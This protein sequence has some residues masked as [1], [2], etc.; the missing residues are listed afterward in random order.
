MNRSQA[1][2]DRMIL[3]LDVPRQGPDI[4]NDDVVAQFHVMS[5]VT[6]SEDV[7]VR[8]DDGCLTIAS[9]AM[10]RD[11]LSK[12]IFVANFGSGQSSFPLQVLSFQADAGEGKNFVAMAKLGMTI[13]NHVGMEMAVVSQ[14]DVFSNHTIRTDFTARADLRAGMNDGGGMNHS[15]QESTS[16]KVTSAS[17]TTSPLAEQIPLALPILPR[18]FTNSTSIMRVSPG[19]TGLRHFTLSAEMK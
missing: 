12:S 9:R 4:G 17:L 16:M 1:A 14:N 19:R 10:N 6:I 15:F 3:N 2:N 7:I 5:Q 18:A 11:I 8:S 13:H